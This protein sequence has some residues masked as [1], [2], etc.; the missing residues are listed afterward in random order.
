VATGAVMMIGGSIGLMVGGPIVHYQKGNGSA[1]WK[2]LA[3]RVG[4]PL[5]GSAI[6]EAMRSEDCSGDVC[7]ETNSGVGSSLGGIGLLT[8]MAI[9]WF[10]LAKHSV[11]VYGPAPY[12]ATGRD[13][14]LSF[15]LTTRF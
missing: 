11:T 7:N 3:L 14:G 12:V 4:L 5:I 2:S 10:V 6:G 1:V 15:G 13:G 9:D 8:A